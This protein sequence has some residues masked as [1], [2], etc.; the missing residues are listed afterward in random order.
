MNPDAP[1]PSAMLQ[2]NLVI[3]LRFW[4]PRVDASHST[5]S[6]WFSQHPCGEEPSHWPRKGDAVLPE[7][8]QAACPWA[9]HLSQ[10]PPVSPCPRLFLWINKGPPSR[11]FS[12]KCGIDRD[13]ALKVLLLS[14]EL[15]KYKRKKRL[16]ESNESEVPGLLPDPHPSLSVKWA[17]PLPISEPDFL[18]PFQPG[19]R[20]LQ[21]VTPELPAA[22]AWAGTSDKAPGL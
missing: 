12:L 10:M 19:V 18:L 4:V 5:A 17:Q 8:E 20:G 22:S 11:T 14:P 13:H 15:L 1:D 6:D 9:S 16:K 7:A 2:Q 3:N 21:A